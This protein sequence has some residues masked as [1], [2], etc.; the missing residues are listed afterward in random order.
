MADEDM[1]TRDMEIEVKDKGKKDGKRFEVKKWN[2]VR[3]IF[4]VFGFAYFFCRLRCGPGNRIA[5]LPTLS[6]FIS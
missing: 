3:A 4:L 5:Q 2:A 1:D 6:Y